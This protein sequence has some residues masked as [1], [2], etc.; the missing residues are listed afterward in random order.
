[1]TDFH[2]PDRIPPNMTGQADTIRARAFNTER[3]DDAERSRPREQ[4]GVAETISGHATVR[5][6]NAQWRDRHGD[7]YVLVCRRR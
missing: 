4:R 1:M 2:D 3:L 6:T 5:E 7:M